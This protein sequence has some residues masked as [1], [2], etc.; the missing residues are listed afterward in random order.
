MLTFEDLHR[1]DNRGMQTLLK[2]IGR[3]DLLLALKTASPPMQERILGNLSARAREI[4]AEDLTTLGPVRLKDVER[5]QAA[6]V[7]AARR[8]AEEQKIQLAVSADD[9]LV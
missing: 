8:L 6:I 4:M 3:D 2:E 7:L 9:A 5:A 1:L